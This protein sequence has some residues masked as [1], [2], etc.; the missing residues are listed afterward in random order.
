MKEIKSYAALKQ[1][2]KKGQFWLTSEW[3]PTDGSE[4]ERLEAIE[5]A[6]SHRINPDNLFARCIWWTN[7]REIIQ[8]DTVK[9]GFHCRQRGA[10][11]YLQFRPA[12]S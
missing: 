8:L 10:T 9:I 6:V 5:H 2:L 11:S 4:K 3:R 1:Y 7:P 12:K